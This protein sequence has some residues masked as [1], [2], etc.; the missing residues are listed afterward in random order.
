VTKLGAIWTICRTAS[1]CPRLS[2]SSNQFWAQARP[3]GVLPIDSTSTAG[4][5]ADFGVA[6]FEDSAHDCNIVA[7]V[8]A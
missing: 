6:G 7:V 4:A 3:L 8:R 5:D 1:I 2:T